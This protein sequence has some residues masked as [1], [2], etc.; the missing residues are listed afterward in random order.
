MLDKRYT[1]YVQSFLLVLPM[2]GL[3]TAIN[4][5]V[6]RG[7][8]AVFTM[9]TLHRWGISLAVAFPCVLVV[10]PMAAKL[11]QRIIRHD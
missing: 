10:A 8:G 7:L 6:A 3:V 4:T 9:S 5:L 1:R 11:T 2:T